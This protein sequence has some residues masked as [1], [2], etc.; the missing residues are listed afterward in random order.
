MNTIKHINSLQQVISN[1]YAATEQMTDEEY[2]TVQDQLREAIALI[3][4][5]QYRL[6]DQAEDLDINKD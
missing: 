5:A 4:A 2:G 3:D 6:I 1:I